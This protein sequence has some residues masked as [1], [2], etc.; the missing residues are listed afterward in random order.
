MREYRL[1]TLDGAGKIAKAEWLD[2]R[3]DDEATVLVRARKMPVD[4]EL[5]DRDRLVANGAGPPGRLILLQP[6]HREPPLFAVRRTDGDKKGC[7][8]IPAPE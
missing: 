2:A 3:S 8:L 6:C 7:T 4:C 5:W 1:Y